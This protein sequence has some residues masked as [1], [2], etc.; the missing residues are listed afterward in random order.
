[1]RISDWS[2]YGSSSDLQIADQHRGEGERDGEGRQEQMMEMLDEGLA[3]ARYREP[4]EPDAEQDDEHDAEPERRQ[5]EP[6]RRVDADELI[7]EPAAVPGRQRR[8]RRRDRHR[9]NHGI[10][11]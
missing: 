6:Q 2:S 3:I 1:M 7:G 5:A 4:A 11:E 8:Q 10:A 9:Q